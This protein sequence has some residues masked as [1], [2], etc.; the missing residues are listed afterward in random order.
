MNSLRI[1]IRL[2]RRRATNHQKTL[3]KLKLTHAEQK[4][5]D[6]DI[7]YL[8]LYFLFPRKYP[9]IQNREDKDDIY[10]AIIS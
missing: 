3:F 5:I 9:K 8:L 2:D 1:Y 7:T 4:L 6:S 10:M